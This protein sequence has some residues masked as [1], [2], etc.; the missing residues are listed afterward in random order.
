MRKELRTQ[1]RIDA[2]PEKVWQI[3]SDF[4]QYPEWNPFV[5][6]VIGKPEVGKTIQVFLPG[7]K[8]HPEV[9]VF[10]TSREFRWKGKLFFS[11]LFDGEHYFI[12]ERNTDGSTTFIHGEKFSGILLP[13]L[14]RSLDKDTRAGFEAMNLALK[15]R[16]EQV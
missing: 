5:K 7:M 3:L 14:A 8:F 9:L 13:L 4:E 16:C 10:D 15:E 11:G 6:K 12:L 2:T 1:V